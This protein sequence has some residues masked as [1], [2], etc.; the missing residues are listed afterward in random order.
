MIDIGFWKEVAA[1]WISI[2]TKEEKVK[3]ASFVTRLAERNN[4]K[5]LEK[6]KSLQ[7]EIFGFS[8]D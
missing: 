8:E 2:Q 6:E 5:G 4:N 7:D 3:I 1:S